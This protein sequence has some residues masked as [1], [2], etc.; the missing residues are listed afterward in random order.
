MGGEY[1]CYT[2]DITCSFPCNGVF[3]EKQKKIYNAVLKASRAVMN[4]V[5][6]GVNW[7]DM[8][9]LADRVHLAELKEYGILRGDVDDMMNVRLGALFM[10]HGLGH[11]LGLDTHDCG[12]YPE[13]IER[14]TEPG[15]RSL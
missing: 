13:G 12:G 8:H 1:Y 14:R 7:V 6:P 3:T 9:K 10:P 5:K 11:F 15:L 2:S 4:A